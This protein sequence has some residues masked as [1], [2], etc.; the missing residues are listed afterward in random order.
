MFLIHRSALKS[1]PEAVCTLKN[2]LGATR[3]ACGIN[4]TLF[5]GAALINNATRGQRIN[6]NIGANY[7]TPLI[8][9]P[10]HL[11]P[12]LLP[13]RLLVRH[14]PIRGRQDDL[15][16]LTAG[17]QID[18]PLLNVTD[19]HVK[20][21]G[22]DAALVEPAVELHNDLLGAVVVHDLEFPDVP[23]GKE[24]ARGGRDEREAGCRG[25]IGDWRTWS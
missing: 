19:V 21:G 17:Q 12:R 8:K 18:D 22:D 16:E 6:L 4:A 9:E 23:W 5:Q 3:R 2:G 14:D 10:Q 1:R 7:P 13:P 25:G 24:R 11:P 20:S 15:A